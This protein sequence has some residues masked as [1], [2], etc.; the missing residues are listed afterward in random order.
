ME[1]TTS[2]QLKVAAEF[3]P[4]GPLLFQEGMVDTASALHPGDPKRQSSL[5]LHQ[6]VDTPHH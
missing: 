5:H 4:E 3:C 2:T 6:L 1:I